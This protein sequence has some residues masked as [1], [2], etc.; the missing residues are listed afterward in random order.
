MTDKAS[1][2][3]W[4]F[5]RGTDNAPD[6]FDPKHI[7]GT[8]FSYDKWH[9]ARIWA[10][11]GS[12]EE[13]LANAALIIKTVNL[14]DELVACLKRFVGYGNIFGHTK[15]ESNPYDDAIDVLAKAKE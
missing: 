12:D 3:P 7:L 2:R 13:S 15:W 11:A 9:V 1:A 6:E 4:E 8:I 10:T 14:H 5:I